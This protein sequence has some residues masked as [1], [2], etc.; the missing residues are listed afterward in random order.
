M[1]LLL[2]E[3]EVELSELVVE[4]LTAF[5]HAVDSVDCVEDAL[6][7]LATIAYDV[8]LLDLRLPDGDGLD[9]L[10]YLRGRT[11][12]TPV[13]ALTARA[14]IEDRVRG[15]NAGADDYVTKPFAMVELAA[16]INAV[17]RRRGDSAGLVLT[18]GKVSFDIASRSVTIDGKTVAVP[19]REL[20]VLELLMRRAGRVVTR[21]AIETAMYSDQDEV[22]TNATEVTVSRLR[23][24][25][26][27]AGV[28]IHTVRGVGWMLKEQA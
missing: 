19:R 7:A 2:V 3:D 27:A 13:I 28:A 16:R 22:G 10:R 23:R 11:A 25:L 15:L 6:A 9:V 24:R 12:S 1:R 5:G 21:D 18:Y 20:Q 4:Q 17:L 26:G 14:A 8:V